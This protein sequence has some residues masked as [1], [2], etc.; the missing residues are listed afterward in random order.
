VELDETTTDYKFLVPIGAKWSDLS[1][2]LAKIS[3][4]MMMNNKSMLLLFSLIL[5][6]FLLALF[7]APHLSLVALFIS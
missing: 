2:Q 7:P 5:F 6:L 4:S 1:E 3:A